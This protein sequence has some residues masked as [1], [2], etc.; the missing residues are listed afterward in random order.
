MDPVAFREMPVIEH[1]FRDGDPQNPSTRSMVV[2]DGIA[3]RRYE[4]R[5]FEQTYP[6]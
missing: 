6:F 4:S 2:I 3:E 5:G 1:L